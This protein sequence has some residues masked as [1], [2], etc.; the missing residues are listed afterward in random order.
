MCSGNSHALS[1]RAYHSLV[2][3]VSDT[4]F[5]ITFIYWAGWHGEWD[6][7]KLVLKFFCQCEA[8]N[9]SAVG[10]GLHQLP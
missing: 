10:A 4:S 6:Q 2:R 3:A 7:R 8:V 5:P 9:S 1:V